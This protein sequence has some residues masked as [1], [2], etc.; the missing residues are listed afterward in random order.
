MRR[1]VVALLGVVVLTLPGSV[2]QATW[3]DAITANSDPIGSSTL[4]AP[5]LGCNNNL[6][7]ATV[8]WTASST[9]TLLTYSAQV[10]EDTAGPLTVVVSGLTRTVTVGLGQLLSTLTGQT[11]TLRV[12]ASLPGTLW[13]T[14]SDV[15]LDVG[16]LGVGVSC[17]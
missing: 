7:S 17:N 1:G 9:P 15:L 5:T 2:T 6:L 4:Q 12:T 14:S 11:V 3:V 10:V 8:T 16:P 13:T